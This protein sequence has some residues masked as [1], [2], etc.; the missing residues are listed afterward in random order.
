MLP[1]LAQ[2]DIEGIKS[3]GVLNLENVWPANHAIRMCF[4]N[5]PQDLRSRVAGI[6]RQWTLYGAID[7]DFGNLSDPRM[8]TGADRNSEVRITFEADGNWSHSGV[9]RGGN[10]QARRR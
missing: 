9:R 6:A 8:C 7:F 10:P 5:G 4:M 3:S 1:V 2:L